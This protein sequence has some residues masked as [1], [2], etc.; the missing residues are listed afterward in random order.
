MTG[1]MGS[2]NSKVCAAARRVLETG[3]AE[4]VVLNPIKQKEFEGW[5]RSVFLMRRSCLNCGTLFVAQGR[6]N[7]LCQSCGRESV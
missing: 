2:G 7:R 4:T 3:R 5:V 6:V 1:S